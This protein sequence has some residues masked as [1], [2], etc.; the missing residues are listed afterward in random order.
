MK[1]KLKISPKSID[2]YA[3][4]DKI[5]YNDALRLFN[6]SPFVSGDYTIYPPLLRENRA[7]YSIHPPLLRYD[8][9]GIIQI[10]PLCYG[11]IGQII[12]SIPFCYTETTMRLFKSS[13]FVAVK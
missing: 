11:K 2:I 4:N 5:R 1:P 6:L 3:D 10:I 8:G 12:Q 9:H 13:P 7:D